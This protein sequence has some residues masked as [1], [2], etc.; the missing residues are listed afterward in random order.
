MITEPSSPAVLDAEETE[1][2]REK[3]V[4]WRDVCASVSA[5]MLLPGRS[6][7]AT[8]FDLLSGRFRMRCST[9]KSRRRSGGSRM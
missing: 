6:L 8:S 9:G 1:A 4:C 5:G 2:A 3:G 7:V